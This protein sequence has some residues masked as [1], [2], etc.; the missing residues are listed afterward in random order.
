[1]HITVNN[2]KFGFHVILQGFRNFKRRFGLQAG[3]AVRILRFRWD[4][5]TVGEHINILHQ[6]MARVSKGLVPECICC[7]CPRVLVGIL[8]K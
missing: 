3:I 5:V 1:M 8:N 4:N 6:V 2:V 7:M